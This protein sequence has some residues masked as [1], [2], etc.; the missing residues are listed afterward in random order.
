[1]IQGIHDQFD[2][3]EAKI[4]NRF[5]KLFRQVTLPPEGS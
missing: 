1:M 4:F 3:A 2:Q 5:P